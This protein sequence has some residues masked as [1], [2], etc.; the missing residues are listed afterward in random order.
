MYFKD[1]KLHANISKVHCEVT[2]T[3]FLSNTN[4]D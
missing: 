3:F 4:K 2:W 1:Q